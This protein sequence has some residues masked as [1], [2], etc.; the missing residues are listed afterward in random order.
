MGPGDKAFRFVPGTNGTNNG[1]HIQAT[2]N[3]TT[4]PWAHSLSVWIKLDDANA[5]GQALMGIGSTATGKNSVLYLYAGTSATTRELQYSN[6][7]TDSLIVPNGTINFV[8]GR[9]YHIV[10]TTNAGTISSS[11]QKMYVDGVEQPTTVTGTVTSGTLNLD[12]NDNLFIGRQSDGYAGNWFDGLMS[13]YK[14][15][16]TVLEPSEVRKLY[17]LGRTGRSMVI[18]DT[19]VGIGKVPEAQL[20]VRGNLKVSGTISSNS[21]GWSYWRNSSADINDV[22]YN[23]ATDGPVGGFST[24]ASFSQNWE[25]G[26]SG[27]IADRGTGHNFNPTTGTYTAPEKGVYM[28]NFSFSIDNGGGGDDSMYVQFQT[29]G[30]SGGGGGWETGGAFVNRTSSTNAYML[31]NPEFSTRSGLEDCWSISDILLLDAGSTV[32]VRLENVSSSSSLTFLRCN[33]SGFKIA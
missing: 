24:L 2:L 15:Y 1:D 5:N 28:V 10:L 7:N 22:I 16:N 31:F 21:P 8:A 25:T 33:F 13:N 12:A 6:Q 4:G 17:N 27:S 11:N 19:A 26:I 32:N 14:I 9:W 29:A 3:T 23:S 20:D 30:N 18:S